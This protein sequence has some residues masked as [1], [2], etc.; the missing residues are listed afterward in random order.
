MTSIVNKRNYRL[1]AHQ[2]NLAVRYMD[3]SSMP[4]RDVAGVSRPGST[5]AGA[6]QSVSTRTTTS[7]IGPTSGNNYSTPELW[8]SDIDSSAVV[9]GETLRAVIEGGNY[10]SNYFRVTAGTRNINREVDLT[11]YLSGASAHG[12]E[13]SQGT[14]LNID[15]NTAFFGMNFYRQNARIISDNLVFYGS[16]NQGPNSILF[17]TSQLTGD[18]R[19]GFNFLEQAKLTDTVYDCFVDFKQCIVAPTKLMSLTRFFTESIQKDSEGNIIERGTLGSNFENC[20]LLAGSKDGYLDLVHSLYS[21][22]NKA[23]VTLNG[24]TVRG[25]VIGLSYRHGYMHH[26]LRASLIDFNTS[27]IS[28]DG[29]YNDSFISRG[30][31][32]SSRF[33]TLNITDCIFKG[34]SGDLID[35]EQ[36]QNA[37]SGLLKNAIAEGNVVNTLFDV[38]FVYGVPPASGE[39]S[40]RPPGPLSSTLPYVQGQGSLGI[41]Y[42]VNSDM[43][44]YDIAG[45]LRDSDPNAGAYEGSFVFVTYIDLPVVPVNLYN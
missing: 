18:H 41:D 1:V 10:G 43:P 37:A 14:R 23:K 16:N 5:D 33:A 36:G 32:Y 35:Q 30:W 34:A 25:P 44:L 12:G 22:A 9:N 17:P 24:C 45:V 11:L 29:T 4:G 21:S 38:P 28:E 2:D 8:F 42:A 6:F 19:Q 40:F 39:V 3:V 15:V 13:I 7:T 31:M 26:D 27:G 20:L